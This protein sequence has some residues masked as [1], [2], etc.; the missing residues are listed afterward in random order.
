MQSTNRLI[1]EKSP[2]LLQHAHDPVD[3]YAWGTEAFT[4][5]TEELKPILLSIGYSTCHWCHV[6]AHESFQDAEVA[7]ELNRA[8]V[9]IK[10]DREERPDIDAVYMEACMAMNGSGGWPLTILMTPE[11]EPFFAGTYLPKTSRYGTVGLMELLQEV[12]RLWRTDRQK[13]LRAGAKFREHLSAVRP[14]RRNEPSRAL[15]LSARESFLREFD[16]QNGGFRGA[17]K[18]PMGHSILFLLEFYALEKDEEALYMAEKTLVQM[19]RGGLYDHLG[20]GFSR[21]STDEKWLVPHFEKMLYDNALL[22]LAYL[23]AFRLTQKPFYALVARQTLDYCIRELT[24]EQGGFLCAQ[25]ADSDGEEGKYYVFSKEEIVTVLGDK[26]GEAFCTAYGVSKPGNF[27]GKNILNLLRNENFEDAS[28]QFEKERQKLYFYRLKR[29]ALHTDDKVL[30]SWNSL[31]IMALSRAGVI[32][33]EQ[34]YIDAAQAA[35]RFILDKLSPKENRLLARWRDDDAAFDGSLHDYAYYALALLALYESTF[36]VNL[37]RDAIGY[38]QALQELFFDADHGGYFMNSKESEQLITRPKETYDGAFPSGNSAAALLFLKLWRLTGQKDVREQMDAQLSFLAGMIASG[39]TGHS[40]ACLAML[41]AL[42][43]SV[44]LICVSKDGSALN[45]MRKLLRLKTANNLTALM[46]TE[47]NSGTL[48]RLAPYTLAYS[49]E[50]TARYY[51]C[52]NGSCKR[53][54]GSAQEAAELL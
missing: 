38:A 23:E 24:N 7:L 32:F 12:E 29:M 11:K 50:S 1:H 26:D 25:D 48:F 39:P 31:M 36:D 5:A 47:T 8:F 4:K 40:F 21:Y 45:D 46:K 44:E 33:Q 30:T 27:E 34:R 10:V 13:L 3:W 51:V 14:V 19:Y 35:R 41:D 43:P 22:S 16:A 53:P 37:L 2:Y 9:C 52:R 49:I 42:S 17:P 20:G 28:A 15:W 18:F 54:V 6:M